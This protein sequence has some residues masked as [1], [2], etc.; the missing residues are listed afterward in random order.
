MC[1]TALA[2]TP[3]ETIEQHFTKFVSRSDVGFVLINQPIADMIRPVVNNHKA[4]IPMVR[5]YL[6]WILVTT[7]VP[8]RTTRLFSR[9]NTTLC[10]CRS[11][12]F[13]PRT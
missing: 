11:L 9:A 3:R 13:R 1:F 2:E 4:I 10:P 6:M 5:A 8:L 12:R 7:G